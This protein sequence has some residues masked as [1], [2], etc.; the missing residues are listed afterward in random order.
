[1]LLASEK[2]ALYCTQQANS[3][4]SHGAAQCSHGSPQ[5]EKEPEGFPSTRPQSGQEGVEVGNGQHIPFTGETYP[6][7]DELPTQVLDLSLDFAADVELVAVEGD[8]L[9]VGQQILLAGGVRALCGGS[10]LRPSPPGRP[11]TPPGAVLSLSGCPQ[12]APSLLGPRPLKVR[13][14]L[15]KQELGSGEKAEC[16]ELGTS[17]PIAP[18]CKHLMKRVYFRPR[19]RISNSK[20]EKEHLRTVRS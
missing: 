3:C 12:Q 7:D 5:P 13:K 9:Q 15:S 16:A 8:A 2:P 20:Q 18:H 17:H 10:G 14:H 19:W 6:G 11:Q 4:C 1:M